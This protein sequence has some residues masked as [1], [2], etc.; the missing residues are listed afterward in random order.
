MGKVIDHKQSQTPQGFSNIID[1]EDELEH[2][3]C[4]QPR[5]WWSYSIPGHADTTALNDFRERLLQHS[6]FFLVRMY[7]HMPYMVKQTSSHMYESSRQSGFD[8]SREFLR[9]YHVLSSRL[10]G[11]PL[12]E[13][14][15]H[16]FLGFM[17]ALLLLVGNHNLSWKGAASQ[18]MTL[19][20]T[21]IEIL[22]RLATIKACKISMQAHRA[23][24]DVLAVCTGKEET[25]HTIPS[26]ICIP[27]FGTLRVA[28]LNVARAGQEGFG[29]KD[30]IPTPTGEGGVHDSRQW[31]E[32]VPSSP[33]GQSQCEFDFDFDFSIPGL[34]D[35][36]AANISFC[37]SLLDLDQ[38][39]CLSFDVDTGGR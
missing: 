38:D 21:T 10:D 17:S 32:G 33:V 11:V 24:V 34:C 3:A 18:D 4:T 37:D 15:T 19:I 36:T 14:K 9:R 26:K 28:S 25:R 22:E 35:N 12:F 20:D 31:N 27:Y 5:Q 39:W 30:P 23:L 29:T 1:I 7:V 8:A 6:L 16:D 2:L 13:C